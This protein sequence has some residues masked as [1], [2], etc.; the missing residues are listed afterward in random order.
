ML[1][2]KMGERV[3]QFSATD[4]N[5]R[6]F[7]ALIPLP[8]GTSY[9]AYLILGS[10]KTA[11]IDTV[12]PTKTSE[13]MAALASVPTLDYVV[14]QHGEQDHSGALPA[15]LARYP[16]AT[17]LATA[18][19]KPMLIDL[20]HLPADRITAVEDGG[21][22]SLGDYTLEFVHLPWVH[23]PETMGTY[24]QE[25]GIL[26]SCDM[27]GSHL[28]TSELYISDEGQVYEAAKRYYAEI[29]MPFARLVAKN[30]E[31]LEPYKIAAQVAK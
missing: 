26:F 8:D 14:S 7:D 4:W 11:L 13:L 1:V 18:K 31:R 19:A 17:V 22:V 5:R 10:E 3:F 6:L 2:H 23:W 12:D 16:K 30:V 29:M 9:N 24:L 21:K 28:A 27:F 20:L 15:V 25:Q